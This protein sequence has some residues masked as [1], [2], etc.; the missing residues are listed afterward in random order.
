VSNTETDIFNL[1]DDQVDAAIAKLESSEEEETF[2]MEGEQEETETTEND[3][4]NTEEFEEDD[5]YSDGDEDTDEEDLETPDTD[6]NE[7]QT[8]PINDT[9]TDED[10]DSEESDE[11]G[12]QPDED[13]PETEDQL[14][15][16]ETDS[17]NTKPNSLEAYLSETSIVKANGK[18]FSFTNQEKLEA[19]DKLYPQ[20]MDYTKKTQAIKPWRK[21]IDAIETAELTHEDVNLMIDVLKGDP[22]AISQV[23]K[24]TG[25]DTLDLD[26]EESNY[27]P[28][29]YGRDETT[30][31]IKDVISRI[32]VDPEY[33]TTQKVLSVDWD[34]ASFK[35]ITSQPQ[36]IEQLHIDVKSGLYDQIQPMADKAK[37]FAGP[38]S[39][40][41]DLDFYIQAANE[42]NLAQTR[43]Q[44]LARTRQEEEAKR[45]EAQKE[46]EKLLKVKAKQKK[47]KQT[48]QNAK[49]RKAAAP[50]RQ[51]STGAKVTDYLDTDSMND[52]EFEKFM[53]KQLKG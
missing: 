6:S 9:P 44:N 20:A 4:T 47:A 35:T 45:V 39:G 19:F 16:E 17:G 21:T 14:T 18:E 27:I 2:E 1:P 43:A 22:D 30:L 13:D 3:S 38:N 34:E 25:V 29:D 51:S 7:P 32:S 11:D 42:Y 8:E 40:K 33:T 48:R 12:E 5:E 53:E 37:L 28:K 36:M 23:L 24:R 26:V 46:A 10:D 41:S 52:E 31:E 49:K 15:D 50:T